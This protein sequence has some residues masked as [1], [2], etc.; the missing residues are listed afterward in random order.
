[1]SFSINSNSMT[2]LR[3]VTKSKYN[4]VKSTCNFHSLSFSSFVDLPL[5]ERHVPL[6]DLSDHVLTS[7]G[8][9]LWKTLHLLSY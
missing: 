9:K 3:H 1:M 8:R 6:L 2:D 5:P 7:T 4:L